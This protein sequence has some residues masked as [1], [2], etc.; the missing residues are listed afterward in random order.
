M[1]EKQ[2]TNVHVSKDKSFS[3][4]SRFAFPVSIEYAR[5]YGQKEA[6]EK[7][8]EYLGVLNVDV[9]NSKINKVLREVRT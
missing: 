9:T 2:Y 3:V 1:E 5:E 4:K 6:E 7:S 8:M